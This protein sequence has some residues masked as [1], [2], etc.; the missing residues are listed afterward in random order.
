[1]SK[2]SKLKK[3]ELIALCEANEITLTGDEVKADLVL[4]LE[5]IVEDIEAEAASKPHD[6]HAPK[7]EG[8]RHDKLG[9]KKKGKRHD[10]HAP[11]KEGKRHD[12]LGPKN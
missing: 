3:A 8:K 12:K 5:D 7:A 9:P 10:K 11:K 1:M 4:I 2:R 6:K